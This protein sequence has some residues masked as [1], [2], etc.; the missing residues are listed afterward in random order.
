MKFFRMAWIVTLLQFSPG[1]IAV[2]SRFPSVLPNCVGDNVVIWHLCFGKHA[3]PSGAKYEGEWENG[4]MS[5]LGV[6]RFPDNSRYVGFFY[7]GEASGVG[8]MTNSDES[9][10]V[11]QFKAGKKTG[12]GLLGQIVNKKAQF[13]FDRMKVFRGKW[14]NDIII[15][16][17]EKPTSDLITQ[18][19]EQTF[20]ATFDR[21]FPIKGSDSNG[22]FVSS[23]VFGVRLGKSIND[24]VEKATISDMHYGDNFTSDRWPLTIFSDS[25]KAENPILTVSLECGVVREE[26]GSMA[27]PTCVSGDHDARDLIPGRNSHFD[28]NQSS[29]YPILGLCIAD[30]IYQVPQAYFHTQ[31]NNFVRLHVREFWVKHNENASI[32]SVGRSKSLKD[33]LRPANPVCVCDLQVCKPLNDEI[34]RERQIFFEALRIA[35][36]KNAQEEQKLKAEKDRQLERE[37][38]QALKSFQKNRLPKILT[39]RKTP[40]VNWE[41]YYFDSYKVEGIRSSEHHSFDPLSAQK[42][43]NGVKVLTLVENPDYFL[44]RLRVIEINC[45]KETYRQVEE[46]RFEPPIQAQIFVG[47]NDIPSDWRFVSGAYVDLYRKICK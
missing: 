46:A 11:G 28:E 32:A 40:W 12:Y 13:K 35:H 3:S 37:K 2:D 38:Q 26:K 36:I 14:E 1:A 29:K 24:Y 6:M 43:A 5:G 23:I 20:W 8:I 7:K 21:G 19:I 9:V 41:S 10:Y 34:A 4:T 15:K 18:L 47:F 45:K 44:I 31:S 22:G 30:D 16:N 17:I 25:S 33:F 42:S 39:H 27:A